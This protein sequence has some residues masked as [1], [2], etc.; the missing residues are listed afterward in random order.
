MSDKRKFGLLVLSVAVVVIM[1]MGVTL[2]LFF[3]IPRVAYVRSPDLVEKFI[4]TIEARSEF[5]TKKDA[6][7]ANV[8][9]LQL[10][11]ER[12]R[13]QYFRIASTLSTSK[14][15]EHEAHLSQQQS[16]FLQ[17]RDAIDQKVMEE[18]QKM[19]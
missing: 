7:L 11:F 17:Y 9:S 2:Y 1:V 10:D 3:S 4:G 12:A 14:R 6:M 13:N 19:M 5:Q 18:D 16:Q 8:D 15:Q